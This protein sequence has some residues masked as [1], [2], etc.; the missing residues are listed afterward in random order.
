LEKKTTQKPANQQTH[1]KNC[2]HES[3]PCKLRN[4]LVDPMAEPLLI[5]SGLKLPIVHFRDI[6]KCPVTVIAT[7]WLTSDG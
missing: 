5:I 3:I 7:P 2:R 4:Y 6:K 1:Q